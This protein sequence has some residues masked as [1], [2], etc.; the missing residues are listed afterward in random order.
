[1]VAAANNGKGIFLPPQSKINQYPVSTAQSDKLYSKN[2]RFPRKKKTHPRII[3]ETLFIAR[4]TPPTSNIKLQ[5][6]NSTIYE[7]SYCS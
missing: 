4:F 6:S 1:M 3:G 5:T 7:Q 2:P